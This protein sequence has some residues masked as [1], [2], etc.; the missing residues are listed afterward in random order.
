MSYLF[1][2]ST[3]DLVIG[4]LD[5]RLNW[6]SF[7]R[8][9]GQKASAIIQTMTYDLLSK[10]QIKP[11]ELKGIF[12][13]NGPGFYTGLRLAE[14]FA[15]VLKF[16]GIPQYSFYSYEIPKWCGYSKGTWFTK[17]YRGEY[18]FY[19]WDE[20]GEEQVLLPAKE[21]EQGFKADRQLFIH[22]P[23][24]LDQTSSQFIQH[25]LETVQLLREQPQSIFQTVL[26]SELKREAFYFRAP[27]DEFKVNP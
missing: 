17:A 8:Q 22:S 20:S 15:D 9:T 13:V 4:V 6:L 18:Y 1:I 25:P 24:S 14:G 10:H 7:E 21:I 12:T 26:S 5:E 11:N 27:E 2:D 23:V 16:F 3:Y 19:H